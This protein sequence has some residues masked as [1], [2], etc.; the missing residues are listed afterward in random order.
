MPS[1]RSTLIFT[2]VPLSAS[3]R[4]QR[5]GIQLID[6]VRGDGQRSP[7]ENHRHQAVHLRDGS[8]L[9]GPDVVC[10]GCFDGCTTGAYEGLDD[11]VDVD[12][13]MSGSAVPVHREAAA[14]IM[15]L[16][17][18]AIT[19]AATART[20]FPRAT[21]PPPT[22]MIAKMYELARFARVRNCSLRDAYELTPVANLVRGAFSKSYFILDFGTDTLLND[23]DSRRSLEGLSRLFRL[24]QVVILL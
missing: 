5:D 10:P 22:A 1:A 4:V 19:P 2:Q 13:V 8:L 11:L 17:R 20:P 9:S 16:P 18:T 23:L 21:A 15:A 3:G 7:I 6:T 14:V 24:S 12:I